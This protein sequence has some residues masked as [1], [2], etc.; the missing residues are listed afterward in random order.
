V[1]TPTSP[2]PRP[3]NQRPTEPREGRAGGRPTSDRE[4]DIAA[5]PERGGRH[6]EADL[7]GADAVPDTPNV[8]AHGSD[9]FVERRRT[10]RGEPTTLGRAAAGGAMST[11][12]WVVGIAVV[13]GLLA[14]FF[15]AR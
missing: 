13:I 10:P 3:P 2:E 5:A 15:F 9:V 14:Y 11:V 12:L 6:T 7:G 4:V 8:A 1:P